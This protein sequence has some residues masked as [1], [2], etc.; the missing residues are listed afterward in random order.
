MY[1]SLLQSQL[2]SQ[3]W[4]MRLFG[5]QSCKRNVVWIVTPVNGGKANCAWPTSIKLLTMNR[6]DRVLL[7]TQTILTLLF[8]C[9]RLCF[10]K[11]LSPL[12]DII[13]F[14]HFLSFH[15]LH[16][17]SWYRR[18]SISLTKWVWINGMQ[19]HVILQRSDARRLLQ[20]RFMDSHFTFLSYRLSTLLIQIV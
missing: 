9:L 15:I 7:L 16:I 6:K 18:R 14:S 12:S 1:V 17:S 19:L 8:F 4:R 20:E 2:F 3:L 10:I 11:Y 13:D 5:V